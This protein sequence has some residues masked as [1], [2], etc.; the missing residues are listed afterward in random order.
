[1]QRYDDG[2]GCV[3]NLFERMLTRENGG[4]E[5]GIKRRERERERERDGVHRRAGPRMQG[6]IT[7]REHVKEE[8]T[9]TG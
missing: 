4:V 3:A 2:D 1:M 9:G 5:G 7:E 6:R 8:R